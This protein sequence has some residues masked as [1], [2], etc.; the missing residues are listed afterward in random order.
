VP[1]VYNGVL[2]GSG[3]VSLAGGHVTPT[4]ADYWVDTINNQ[5]QES[6]AAGHRLFKRVGWFQLFDSAAVVFSGQP[7]EAMSPPIWFNCESEDVAIPLVPGGTP[8]SLYYDVA[9]GCSVHLNVSA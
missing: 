7:P 3:T 2:T 9:P 8:D 4:D 1:S 6:G 5:V